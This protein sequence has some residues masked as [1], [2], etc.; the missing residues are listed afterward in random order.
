M[1]KI[2]KQ[3]HQNELVFFKLIF[4][5]LFFFLQSIL[6]SYIIGN[7]IPKNIESQHSYSWEY[8]H[9][10]KDNKAVYPRMSCF[11]FEEGK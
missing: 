5:I 9:Q 8:L 10:T 7:L 1:P 3:E 4:Y 11:S 2:N 6:K